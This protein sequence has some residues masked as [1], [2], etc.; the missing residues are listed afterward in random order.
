MSWG[1]DWQKKKKSKPVKPGS[2]VEKYLQLCKAR[3][4]QKEDKMSKLPPN[5]GPI[6][7][8]P[9]KPPVD[10][11]Q[12]NAKKLFEDNKDKP[13]KRFLL[14][15]KQLNGILKNDTEGQYDYRYCNLHT[16]LKLIYTIFTPLGLGVFQSLEYSRECKCNIINTVIYDL[17]KDGFT[18]FSSSVALPD[19]QSIKLK[20]LSDEQ[21]SPDA[22]KY[23]INQ[24]V[25]SSITYFRRYALTTILNVC[26]D[27]DKDGV[28]G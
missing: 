18:L 23:N 21:S 25:G 11:A 26:P 5:N 14:A 2:Y 6:E 13:N 12:A 10:Q 24:E 4:K 9:S 17:V 27:P 15:C 20:I 16:L 7:I 22:P 3:H 28:G 19:H 8:D 1:Y